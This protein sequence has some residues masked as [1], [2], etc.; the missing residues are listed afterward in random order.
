[1]KHAFRTVVVAALVVA[2]LGLTGDAA[3]AAAE[4]GEAHA[5]GE[6]GEAH[7]GWEGEH[8]SV[9]K[10]LPGA[11]A[12]NLRHAIGETWLEGNDHPH[13]S[14]VF[15]AIIVFALGLLFMLAAHARLR[16]E[17]AVLPP[18]RWNA[19]AVFDIIIEAVLDLMTKMMP[20]DKALQYLPLCTA[21]A[22][23]IF[24]ANFLGLVPGFLPATDNLNTTLALG[25]VAFLA[26][27]WW[28]IRTHGLLAHLKHFLGPIIWLAPL[29]LVIELISHFVRP[30]SLA[31]RLMGNMFGDHM[32]LGIFLGFH[33]LF[34]PLP[35]MALGLIVVTVQALVFTLLTIV[36]IAM[37]VEEHE[38]EH[39]APGAV[40]DPYEAIA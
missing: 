31:L 39:E 13:V 18:K 23:F 35:V 8:W 19:F 4:A 5:A 1:M 36:Y 22:V 33:V 15:M 14:H 26:Y 30:I 32:V 11:L 20:R 21:L 34:V 3:I 37:A 16:K 7:G 10:Y 2:A 40:E 38:H 17:D 12:T 27:N 25:V 6:V 9:L 28:G 24:M 29:M